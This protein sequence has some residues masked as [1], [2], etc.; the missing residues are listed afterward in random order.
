M[1]NLLVEESYEYV[2]FAE[3]STE[4]LEKAFGK[5]RQGSGGAF[6]V[7]AQQA[8]EKLRINQV[9]LQITSGSEFEISVETTMHRSSYCDYVLEVELSSCSDNNYLP[10]F[11]S[12]VD[13]AAKTNLH[14]AGYAV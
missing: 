1:Q 14:I 10:D 8:I 13:D 2:G 7:T 12:S 11:E 5:L 6:F 3:F 9:S 4:R